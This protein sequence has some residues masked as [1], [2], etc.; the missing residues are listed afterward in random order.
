MTAMVHAL[1]SAD[2][3]I[4]GTPAVDEAAADPYVLPQAIT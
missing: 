4:D 3:G 1:P 2:A